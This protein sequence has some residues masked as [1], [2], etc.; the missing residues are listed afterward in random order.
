MPNNMRFQWLLNLSHSLRVSWNSVYI[1]W[2][3][4]SRFCFTD[5]GG[6]LAIL[7]ERAKTEVGN[8]LLG[9]DVSI[10]LKFSWTWESLRPKLSTIF[11]NFGIHDSQRCTF[12]RQTQ[13]PSFIAL[14]INFY[15]ISPWPYPK[16]R[17]ENLFHMFYSYTNYWI[18]NIGSDPALSTNMRGVIEFVY[19]K[20]YYMSKFGGE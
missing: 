13:L 3:E 18:Y 10:S 14:S 16:A 9:I 7:I 1:S 4:T 15:A 6:S 8:F 19:E 20:V 2:Y 11:Y 5:L 17:V 12:W